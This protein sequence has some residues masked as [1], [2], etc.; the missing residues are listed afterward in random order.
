[1]RMC[2]QFIE[3]LWDIYVMITLPFLLVLSSFF[4]RL[5]EMLINVKINF[6]YRNWKIWQVELSN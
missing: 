6:I 3:L 1:M 2:E 5:L 4:K